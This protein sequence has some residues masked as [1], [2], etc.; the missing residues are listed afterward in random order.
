MHSD[1]DTKAAGPDRPDHEAETG[2]HLPRRKVRGDEWWRPTRRKI[3]TIG[4][5]ILLAI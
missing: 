4:L 1:T 5:I 2:A 3:R